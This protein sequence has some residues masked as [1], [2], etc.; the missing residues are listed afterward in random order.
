MKNYIVRLSNLI[1]KTKKI[2]EL[3]GELD[4][5]F[6]YKLYE[7]SQYQSELKSIL[8]DQAFLTMM[9]AKKIN[10]NVASWRDRKPVN[11]TIF[12][13]TDILLDQMWDNDCTEM[14]GNILKS[15][16][17]NAN[18]CEAFIAA[19]ST[20]HLKK[21]SESAQLEQ[22]VKELEPKEQGVLRRLVFERLDKDPYVKTSR[23]KLPDL[24]WLSDINRHYKKVRALAQAYPWLSLVCPAQAIEHYKVAYEFYAARAQRVKIQL[25]CIKA[26]MQYPLTAIELL[27]LPSKTWLPEL[28]ESNK[29]YDT[30][31][32][33]HQTFQ[34]K[35]K[36]KLQDLL[37]NP[38]ED[39][40]GVLYDLKPYYHELEQYFESDALILEQR[41]SRASGF[42]DV[43]SWRDF[44]SDQAGALMDV[45]VDIHESY[46]KVTMKRFYQ[47][48]FVHDDQYVPSIKDA[49]SSG[50]CVKK[51][52]GFLAE[53]L[54]KKEQDDWGSFLFDLLQ[55]KGL[56]YTFAT[57][58]KNTLQ[59]SKILDYNE[60]KKINDQQ[61]ASFITCREN[62]NS[63]RLRYTISMLDGDYVT[64]DIRADRQED[65]TI[66]VIHVRYAQEG[67][68]QRNRR[69]LKPL[70]PEMP[71][72]LGAIQRE[73]AW[74]SIAKTL[75]YQFAKI[76][77]P[78]DETNESGDQHFNQA[79]QLPKYNKHLLP[80][81]LK[82]LSFG[83][84]E[85]NQRIA[86][87]KYF[88][89]Y[90]NQANNTEKALM[91][92]RVCPYKD[93]K[94]LVGQRRLLRF[95]ADDQF[96]RALK[97][98]FIRYALIQ[99]NIIKNIPLRYLKQYANELVKQDEHNEYTE[100]LVARLSSQLRGRL[101]AQLLAKQ[102]Q[103]KKITYKIKRLTALRASIPLVSVKKVNQRGSSREFTDESKDPSRHGALTVKITAQETK[104]QKLNAEIDNIKQD[105]QQI[106]AMVK[107]LFDQYEQKKQEY[108]KQKKQK[109]QKQGKLRQKQEEQKL[110][111]KQAELRQ[112]ARVLRAMVKPRGWFNKTCLLD[113]LTPQ[114][115]AKLYTTYKNNP[116]FKAMKAKKTYCHIAWSNR[117]YMTISM[118][119]K[120]LRRFLQGEKLNSAAAASQNK[121]TGGGKNTGYIL[122][123]MPSP[124]PTSICSNVLDQ[125][126]QEKTP[127]KMAELVKQ[128]EPIVF[129]ANNDSTQKNSM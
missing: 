7:D 2:S 92:Y 5:H 85:V 74:K 35:F 24:S 57:H 115:L 91:Y 84:T 107:T 61:Q 25:Q 3:P 64:L 121:S 94:R 125:V 77:I 56:V 45:D 1:R 88:K 23:K 86:S 81:V 13:L 80:S 118:S 119:P 114:Q 72:T 116:L 27:L 10:F 44:Y 122:S 73:K 29:D 47:M 22:H 66:K 39:K 79:F 95:L 41:F 65:G 19:V 52:K 49:S 69:L 63:L 14:R 38:D 93:T 82:V 124:T 50:P 55:S 43:Y 60:I 30:V 15:V 26:P 53:K 36:T 108:N 67:K 51:F 103:D 71:A 70:R 120:T 20:D 9:A 87:S 101:I 75:N 58:L 100:K 37:D 111:Q 109:K 83:D 113:L 11:A 16:L 62:K 40:L 34:E 99:R 12:N 105:Q 98:T 33:L 42:Q 31:D 21:L 110:R 76:Y 48:L 102:A 6:L 46:I 104:R 18:K 123:E 4:I 90:F 28:L 106:M 68:L 127:E 78:L 129:D 54:N 128:Q 96:P 17:K 32:E 89:R 8:A 97:I 117:R 126:D 59:Y 112:A